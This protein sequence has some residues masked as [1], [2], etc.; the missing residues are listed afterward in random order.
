MRQH[1]PPAWVHS[2]FRSSVVH[3]AEVG[4]DGRGTSECTT[5]SVAM[6]RA[7]LVPCCSRYAICGRSSAVERGERREGV[8]HRASTASSDRPRLEGRGQMEDSRSLGQTGTFFIDYALG[9]LA[10]GPSV[11]FARH[12]SDHP[13]SIGAPM[14]ITVTNTN[15][16]GEGSLRQAMAEVSSGG[17]IV[18]DLPSPATIVLESSLVVDRNLTLTGPTSGLLTISGNDAVRVLRINGNLDVHLSNLT[19]SHGNAGRE[20]G[21]GILVEND[22]SDLD[23]GRLTLFNCLVTENHAGKGGGIYSDHSSPTVVGGRITGNSASGVGGG[24]SCSGSNAR[25]V[26]VTVSGNAADRGGGIFCGFGSNPSLLRSR[27]E[28]TVAT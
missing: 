21:G 6:T 20:N 15:D 2:R 4:W 26:N 28:I 5:R 27:D 17:E 14:T 12:S 18:S 19:L 16:G 23:S 25:F 3:G 1:Q 11:N 22:G 13:I 9:D 24:I 10:E 7:A 8:R